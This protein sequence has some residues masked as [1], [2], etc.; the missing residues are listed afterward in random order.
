[1]K[2]GRILVTPRSVT[3][4]GGHPALNRLT[5]AG[6]EV[7]FCARGRQPT[8]EE[9]IALLPGCAGYLAG[10]E[11]IAAATL[12][13]AGDLRV[14]SRN[15]V[16]VSNIDLAAAAARGIVICRALGANARGVA[17]LTLAHLLALARWV[18]F[19]DASIKAGGWARRKG[20]ELSGKTLGLV[21][22]GAIGR[23]VATLALAFEMR[24]L[25]YDLA[26]AGGFA[27]PGAFRYA[28]LEETLADA[29]VVSL[30][31][32]PSADG[33]PLMDAAALAR[34][35]RGALLINTARAELVDAVA[36]A[37]ALDDG[38]V[39]GYATDVFPTEPPQADDPLA[40][41]DRVIASAHIGSF[42]EESVERAMDVAVDNLLRELA[43][44]KGRKE[45]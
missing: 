23:Q 24:V 25:A 31:C 34:M 41:H 8:G 2:N 42:T 28:T 3:A 44:T 7:T 35:R 38:R 20:F 45:S 18:P 9:L 15:G 5:D 43:D 26:P 21:G 19:S 17:E 33:R 13:A 1:M 16:G 22:C 11:P 14:I 27:P 29:D 4:A 30:H 12:A 32:P 37:A 40:R 36:L 6:Y 39:A 10:V